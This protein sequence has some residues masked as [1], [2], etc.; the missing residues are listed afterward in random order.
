MKKIISIFLIAVIL[1]MSCSCSFIFPSAEEE[2][3]P[4]YVKEGNYVYF[5]H[6]FQGAMPDGVTITTDENGNT[7]GSDGNY[8]KAI[9]SGTINETN[10]YSYYKIE[11]I[12]WIVINEENGILTLMCASI[13]DHRQYNGNGNDY[14]NSGIHTWLTNTFYNA[15]F[16]DEEKA[17][18]VGND[19][20][21]RIWLMSYDEFC[22]LPLSASELALPETD[23][24]N[25]HIIG[26]TSK[27][28]RYDGWALSSYT[29]IVGSA[30]MFNKII[31]ID[32]VNSDGVC[33]N[34][35]FTIG[36]LTEAVTYGVVPVIKIN[37]AD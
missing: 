17:I 10:V 28:S 30:S 33:T 31:E 20:M 9:Y 29:E 27:A 16:S 18:M 12:K 35:Q 37:T 21:A 11:P 23:Y 24:S 7:I 3:E 13:I 26:V 34:P 5:G 1:T 19:A 2:K 14:Y 25:H 36:T 4:L 22:S 8:Y 32:V 6:Y 15:A